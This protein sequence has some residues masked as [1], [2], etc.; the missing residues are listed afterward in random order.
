M[1]LVKPAKRMDWVAAPL[2]LPKNPPAM[3]RLTMGYRS[4]N[5]ATIKR[6]RSM[7]HIDSI[8]TD[9]RDSTIFAGTDF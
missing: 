1:G 9:V 3:F 5:A 2:N 8:L 7:H 4:I 6:A